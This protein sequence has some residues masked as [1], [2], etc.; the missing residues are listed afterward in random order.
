MK[1]GI[2][3]LVVVMCLGFAS[4]VTPALADA[5][6]ALANPL[7]P[8]LLAARERSPARPEPR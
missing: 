4:S 7:R 6:A 1:A 8:K 2:V 5:D 3:S